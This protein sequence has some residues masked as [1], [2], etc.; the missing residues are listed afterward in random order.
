MSNIIGWIKGHLLVVISV[1]MIVL[2]LPAGFYFSNGLNSAVKEKANDAYSSKDRELK[3]KSKVSYSLPAV[4]EGEEVLSESRVPNKVV[5]EFYKQQKADR[6][7][8]VDEVI[9]RGVAL[10]KRDHGHLVDG[11][12]PKPADDRVLRRLGLEM[13]EQ[14]AGTMDEPQQSVYVRLLRR[15]NA[16]APIEPGVLSASLSD[17]R[18]RTRDG[19]AAG[20]ADDKLTAVQEAELEQMLIS[21]RLGEYKGRAE[22]LTF[23]C[24]TDAIFGG[25]GEYSFV[26]DQAP[27]PSTISAAKAFAWLWDYWVITDVLEAVANTNTN[28]AS[29]A[30]SIPNA[31][32]KRVDSI[33]VSKLGFIKD[34]QKSGSS[35]SSSSP[36]D[37]VVVWR[38]N[39]QTG[40]DDDDGYDDRG[41]SQNDPVAAVASGSETGETY[42]GH[43][44]GVAGSSYDIRMVELSVVV[45]SKQLPK[46][47]DALGKTNYMTVTDVDLREVDVWRDLRQGYFYGSEHVVR[48]VLQI[49]TVWLRSWTTDF[50]PDEVRTALGVPL[51]ADPA[52]D[53]L[54]G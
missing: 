41:G 29:G 24:T 13:A 34:D 45:N 32:V 38:G 39:P 17:F 22:E 12:L 44:G 8:Q 5:T 53:G 6:A 35:N 52:I 48:A 33:R 27:S 43:S 4:L 10:N 2:F 14:I 11:L 23:Y 54:D 49:E 25:G 19:L 18:D 36:D 7:A 31:P 26:P 20:S 28:A 51:E 9:E 15:L 50:M 37:S 1:V 21:K 3:G 16:D 40:Y 42:T 47:F 46:L 30:I